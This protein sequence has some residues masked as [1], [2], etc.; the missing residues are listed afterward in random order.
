V[1]LIN[2]STYIDNFSQISKGTKSLAA[3]S[4]AK[5]SGKALEVADAGDEKGGRWS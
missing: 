1:N 4:A 3:A 2:P 5:D